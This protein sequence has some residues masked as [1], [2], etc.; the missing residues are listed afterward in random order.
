[1]IVRRLHGLLES[2]YDVESHC[3]IAD[4]LV[5]DR[6]RLNGIQ[7]DNDSRCNEEQLLLAQTEEGAEVSLFID[8]P[9]L[10]RLEAQD[11]MS[12][13]TERNL[14]DFCT[15]LEGV[16]HFL[17]A[18]WRL[19]QDTPMSLLELETQAEVD[20]FALSVF[21]LASQDGGR[22]PTYVFARLFDAARFDSRLNAEQLDRYSAA[23]RGAARYCR[24][25]EKRFVKRGQARVEG[26]LRELRKF[27]RLGST[28]KLDYA[29]AAN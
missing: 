8:D 14:P 9:V 13:L 4:F 5:T 19:R 20:K 6:N 11:P 26:L 23:H 17:Y 7:P 12:A 3:D 25:L 15:A 22:Y 16:S 18:I 28:A 21:L 24:F 29:L 2:L 10:R 1:M 27:Y